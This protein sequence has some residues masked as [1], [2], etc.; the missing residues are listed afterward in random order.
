MIA[1]VSYLFLPLALQ[2]LVMFFDEFY[3]HRG[4]GLPTWEK[5]GHPLDTLTVL[6]VFG[7]VF[8]R[9]YS[10]SHA[11]TYVLLSLIS[12]FFILKDEWIHKDL[13][14]AG[15]MILHGALFILHPLVF[16]CIY[17]FWKEGGAWFVF[18]ELS[19]QSII[20]CQLFATGL[21]FFYQIFYWSYYEPV[22]SK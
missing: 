22:T 5:I 3:Y 6:L 19:F 21:F 4:R 8:Y 11:V 7:F 16:I 17:L 13:C 12:S 14:S 15:E 18:W 2:A 9:P 20:K 10:E 1:N